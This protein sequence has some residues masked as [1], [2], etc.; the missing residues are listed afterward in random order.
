MNIAKKIGDIKSQNEITVLQSNRWNDILN[1]TIEKSGKLNLG[2]SFI[3]K[4][5]EAIHLESILIQNESV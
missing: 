4:Y 1:R 3:E 5:M 2:K